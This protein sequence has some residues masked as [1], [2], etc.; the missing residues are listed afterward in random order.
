MRMTRRIHA[1]CV[2]V[3]ALVVLAGCQTMTGRTAGQ[4]I[5]DK[6]TTAKVKTA[7][8]GIKAGTVTRV[9]VDTLNGT[10]FL[11]GAVENPTVKSEVLAVARKAADGKPVVDNLT[12][13]PAASTTSTTGV[14]ASPSTSTSRP[15]SDVGRLMT[16]LRLSRLD[17]EGPGRWVA[18]DSSGRRVATVVPVP[19]R[20]LEQQG[21]PAIEASGRPIQHVSIY[22]HPGSDGMQYHVV[23]W[24]VTRDEAMRLQ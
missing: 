15:A 2:A 13:T 20:Q 16:D 3:A 17:P 23:L 12:I 4:Y 1:V 9:D 6:T 14:A 5:D 21:V 11:T 8:A 19:G 22:P 7:L 18:F 10:V 24:H